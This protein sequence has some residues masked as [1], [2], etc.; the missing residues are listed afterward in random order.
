[1]EETVYNPQKI[2]LETIQVEYTQE[3]TT[4]FDNNENR[5]DIYMITDF[6]GGMLI[7]E[8]DYTYPVWVYDVS[9]SEINYDQDKAKEIIKELVEKLFVI[10][11]HLKPYLPQTTDKVLEAIAKHEKPEKP[12]FERV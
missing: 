8:C 1:M 10:A 3:N 4:W 2:K 6:D 11:V 12:L 5:E 7:K 9:R